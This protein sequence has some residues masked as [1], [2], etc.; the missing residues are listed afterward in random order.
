MEIGRR[1]HL[2]RQ[3]S[4]P[5]PFRIVPPLPFLRV[6]LRSR[7][8]RVPL[9]EGA[10]AALVT[11]HPLFTARLTAT[12][13]ARLMAMATATTG[14]LILRTQAHVSG[15]A[16]KNPCHSFW[17]FDLA[18]ISSDDT[19]EEPVCMACALAMLSHAETGRSLAS[20]P[21]RRCCKTTLEVMSCSAMQ[22]RHRRLPVQ[23]FCRRPVVWRV[24]DWKRFSRRLAM[25]V[26]Y[27]KAC[28]VG[29]DA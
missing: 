28:G 27:F 8:L 24:L 22:S 11:W 12:T 15:M 17:F 26:F 20:P 23:K 3:K 2:L 25:V 5:P 19:L 9:A 16:P 21:P 6:N 18:M 1:I 13:V 10:T 7:P 29:S 14:M 4:S